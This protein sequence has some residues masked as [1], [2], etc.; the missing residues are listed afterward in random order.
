M[1]PSLELPLYQKLG[2]I[3]V[4]KCQR[5]DPLHHICVSVIGP[6][7]W[8]T[9]TLKTPS[10]LQCWLHSLSHSNVSRIVFK[11]ERES[12]EQD[13]GVAET[14][15]MWHNFVHAAREETPTELYEI[16]A[17]QWQLRAVWGSEG[18]ASADGVVS[19]IWNSR[20]RYAAY[21]PAR[22]EW[23]CQH[24]NHYPVYI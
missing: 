8:G 21:D 3:Y 12:A 11:R 16:P 7:S 2:L 19:S 23:H 5:E 24:R 9:E 15:V 20:Q 18:V 1:T 14:A 10:V 6:C 4:G 13:S 22:S 17:F